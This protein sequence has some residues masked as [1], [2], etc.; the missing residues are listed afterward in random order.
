MWDQSYY[1]KLLMD[2]RDAVLLHTIIRMTLSH[3]DV[4]TALFVKFLNN[5]TEKIAT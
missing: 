2:A 1:D 4:F 3:L 5:A